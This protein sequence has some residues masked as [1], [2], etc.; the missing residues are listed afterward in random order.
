[1]TSIPA[2]HDLPEPQ[3]TDPLGLVLADVVAFLDR[4]MA[5]SE[6]QL[7]ALALWVALTYVADRFDVV[8]YL[9]VTSPEK[10]S[11][12]SLLLDLLEH[13]ACRGRSTANIS[14]AALYRMVAEHHPTLLIDEVDTIFASKGK[15]ADPA[16]SDLAGLINA[17]FRKGRPAYRMGGANMRT[18]EEFDAF[19]PKALA[20]IGNCLPDTT[21]DRCVPIRLA[22]KGRDVTKERYRIRLHESE[23]VALGERVGAA[24][25]A[26]NLPRSWPHLPDELNDRQQDIWE[27]LLAIA[28][29][30]GGEWPQRARSAALDLHSGSEDDS[31][32]VKL[33]G[34]IRIVFTDD[35]ILTK[36][37]VSLL[38]DLDEAPWS[39]WR[40]DKGISSIQLVN[41]LKAFGIRS[42]PLRVGSE[43]GRGF[44]LEQFDDAFARYLPD[45]TVDTVD[46]EPNEQVSNVNSS[47]NTSNPSVDTRALSTLGQHFKF[48]SVDATDQDLHSNVNTVNGGQQMAPSDER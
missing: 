23:S 12:K 9:F 42:H 11:G 48:A 14:P 25:T 31:L 3:A 16:K 8:A 45:D 37:L 4:F 10:R 7:Y 32:G 20:G 36:G 43:R 39:G 30:A 6:P 44:E 15:N 47:V 5:A 13:L 33:L 29:A 46:N 2:M 34:D 24:V 22:R 41:M 27:P 35:K 1:M 21:C 17:G 26:L 40:K 28:D 38:N 18:L 19:G